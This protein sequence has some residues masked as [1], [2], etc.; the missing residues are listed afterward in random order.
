MR[1]VVAAG[2]LWVLFSSGVLL[3]VVGQRRLMRV[4]DGLL[5]VE[6]AALVATSSLDSD[7]AG[8]VT[9]LVVCPSVTG[10]FLVHCLQR[11]V[12][13]ARRGPRP[14]RGAR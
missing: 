8:A 1:L 4:A 3:N 2:T 11:A 6:F 5:A 10:G 9:A 13:A 7:G 14:L 12:R